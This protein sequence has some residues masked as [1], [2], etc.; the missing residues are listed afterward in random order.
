MVEAPNK[1]GKKKPEV[2]PL[3]IDLTN[4]ESVNEVEKA[5]ELKF[6]RLD[7]LINNAGYMGKKFSVA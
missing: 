1:A 6:G 5:L 2:L 4:Q 3:F 7:I